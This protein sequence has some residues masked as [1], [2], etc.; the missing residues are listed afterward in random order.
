MFPVP[1]AADRARL[2]QRMLPAEAPRMPDLPLDRIA[3]DYEL[4]GGDIQVAALS[5][6]VLAADAREPIG[7][8]HLYRGIQRVLA[9]NGLLPDARLLRIVRGEPDDVTRSTRR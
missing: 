9:K 6:A 8:Y 3:A 4:A 2:W 7:G 5:A 1:E